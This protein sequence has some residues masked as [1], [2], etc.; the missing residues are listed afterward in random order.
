TTSGSKWACGPGPLCQTPVRHEAPLR[1]TDLFGH[2]GCWRNGRK[3]VR[4]EGV[5]EHDEVAALAEVAPVPDAGEDPVQVL[6]W[7]PLDFLGGQRDA[8]RN[9]DPVVRLASPGVVVAFVVRPV[10]GVD[11]SGRPVDCHV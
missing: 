5:L 3:K 6:A 10:C 9:G 11:R 8:G 4:R 1:V 7:R 2:S